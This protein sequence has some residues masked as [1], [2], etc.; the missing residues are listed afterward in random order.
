MSL[1]EFF[2]FTQSP[3]RQLVRVSSLG[4]VSQA[5]HEHL[6]QDDQRNLLTMLKE[7]LTAG[8]ISSQYL[9]KACELWGKQTRKKMFSNWTFQVFGHIREQA[10]QWPQSTKPWLSW[11]NISSGEMLPAP[12]QNK[13]H[14]TPSEFHTLISAFTSSNLPPTLPPLS[15]L[16]SH[17]HTH[18]EVEVLQ[19]VGGG[20]GY[21]S[22]SI[23][24]RY[25]PV[26]LNC[27]N[28]LLSE[29]ISLVLLKLSRAN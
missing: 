11:G 4:F 14:T 18:F 28:M 17:T 10:W 6:S 22:C 25:A 26:S 7:W 24:S 15:Q 23:M 5:S 2:F 27:G 13:R 21:N 12:N 3:F 1:A 29:L 16:L 8:K 20:L 9:I 19:S